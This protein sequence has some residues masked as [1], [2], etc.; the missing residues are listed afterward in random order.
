MVALCNR[1]DHCIFALL[2]LSSYIFF[3][4]S[5]NLSGRRLDV[6]HTLTHGVALVRIYNAGLKGAAVHAARCKC[7]TQKSRQK[8]PSGHH[9]T[10]L[11][12]Y[13]FATKACIDNR[14]KL[15]KQQ[16]NISSTCPHNMVNFSPLAAEIVSLVWGI[17][18]NF[19]G[20]RVLAAL[21]HG[22][23]VVGV[24]QTAALNRGRHLY[25]AGRPSRWALA[26]ILV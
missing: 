25:S 19:N 14:K 15:V 11:S 26:H 2:F 5:P 3:Y 1:A 20:F 16:C 24:S 7:R 10:T 23:I 6:Y 21:L 17:P 13:I 8:S 18:G 12:G 4:S 9:P 22:T